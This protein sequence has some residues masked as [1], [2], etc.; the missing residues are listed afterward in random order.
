MMGSVQIKIDMMCVRLLGTRHDQVPA[1]VFLDL[2]AL[3]VAYVP[4][5]RAD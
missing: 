2:S 4:L 3:Q 5:H 1:F